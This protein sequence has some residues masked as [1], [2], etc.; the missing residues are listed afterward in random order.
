MSPTRTFRFGDAG[1]Q[2]AAFGLWRCPH[3]PH[4]VIARRPQGRR[5]L[6]VL[7]TPRSRRRPLAFGK[8]PNRKRLKLV[9]ARRRFLSLDAE[10]SAADVRPWAL[11]AETSLRHCEERSDEAIHLCTK[12]H[13]PHGEEHCACNASR[14]TRDTRFLGKIDL[15]LRDA[16]QCIAPQD[17]V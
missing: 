2:A 10:K 3:K 14:T 15:V 17:E 16:M 11:R 13:P 12:H 5:G 4:F 8:R 6:F 7:E 9:I 1:K